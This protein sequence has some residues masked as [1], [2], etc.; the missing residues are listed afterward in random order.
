MSNKVPF[1]SIIVPTYN[2][3]HL[4]KRTLQSV[5]DQEF[6]D[7]E[8]I[9]VDDGGNDNTKEI[10]T[11][12]N[13]DRI[14]YYKK[15]NTE[16]GASRNYGWSKAQGLYIT[17]LDSDDIFYPTHLK[18]AHTFLT[19]NWDVY[20]YAQAYETKKAET[21]EV[22]FP[23]HYKK[24]KTI[25]KEIIKG[26][27]LSC[28]GVFIKRE[29]DEELRFEEDRKFAGTEDWLLWLQLAARYPFY[30]SNNVTGALL[31]HNDRS[32]TSFKEE[33]LVYRS[34]ALVKK[35]SSD[36]A[37]IKAFGRK[38]IKK[39]YAHMLSYASLHLAMGSEKTKA[40]KYWF[41]AIS[42]N[43]HELLTKRSLAITKKILFS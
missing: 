9:V 29:I 37:F 30:Y 36:S 7:Y 22:L 1:I 27:F 14:I 26:N 10:V 40:F 6:D 13:D 2:R 18:E 8:L 34:E 35:L 21:D 4:I 3:A 42:I 39:I 19:T 5:L 16:R 15:D 23:P 20:C 25:N 41:K 12:M 11:C 17:F 32:V 24:T 28:F 33:S 43:I 31:E 38:Q